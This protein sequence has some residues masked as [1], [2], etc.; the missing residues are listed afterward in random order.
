MTRSL[1]PD[2]LAGGQTRARFPRTAGP[3]VRSS[4]GSSH[5]R[6]RCGRRS[7][8]PWQGGAVPASAGHALQAGVGGL[9]RHQGVGD[10]ATGSRVEIARLAAG[11]VQRIQTA[12]T[13]F[14]GARLSGGR[15]RRPTSSRL[16]VLGR[17]NLMPYRP[18]LHRDE[19][20]ASGTA[21]P[22]VYGAPLRLPRTGGRLGRKDHDARSEASVAYRGDPSST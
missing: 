15:Y 5:D 22:G 21:T 6:S 4:S 10:H 12:A 2:P 14:G 17:A 20:P 7:S 11:K 13:L 19:Y 1:A 8:H 16:E 18:A 3:G 9:R